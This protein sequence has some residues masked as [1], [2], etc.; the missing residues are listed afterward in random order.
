M[1]VAVKWIKKRCMVVKLF[2]ARKSATLALSE[3]K[4]KGS[5]LRELEGQRVIVLEVSERCRARKGWL[6]YFLGKCEEK[7]QNMCLNS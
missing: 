7:S 2:K 5:S 1:F 4:V 6:F 3:R